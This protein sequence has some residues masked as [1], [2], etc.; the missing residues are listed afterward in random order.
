[1]MDQDGLYVKLLA[2]KYWAQRE[3]GIETCP[4]TSMKNEMRKKLMRF[5]EIFKK[6]ITLLKVTVLF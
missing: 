5:L 6:I 4:I 3:V 2:N 1:M